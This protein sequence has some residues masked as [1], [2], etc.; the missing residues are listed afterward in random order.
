[1]PPRRKSARALAAEALARQTAQANAAATME[2]AKQAAARSNSPQRIAAPKAPPP[3]KQQ[4]AKAK[5]PAPR[6]S[7]RGRGPP[8]PFFDLPPPPTPRIR[9]DDEE[10]EGVVSHLP[11]PSTPLR[12]VSDDEI[13]EQPSTS[14]GVMLQPVVAPASKPVK[15]GKGKKKKQSSSEEDENKEKESDKQEGVDLGPIETVNLESSDEE[16]QA[17][18]FERVLAKLGD[19]F[20]VVGGPPTKRATPPPILHPMRIGTKLITVKPGVTMVIDDMVH[21][22]VYYF[23]MSQHKKTPVKRL[24]LLKH[25]MNGQKK[26]YNEALAQGEAVLSKVCGIKIVGLDQGKQ[27]FI[28][29]MAISNYLSDVAELVTVRSADQ[30][31]KRAALFLTLVIMFMTNKPLSEDEVWSLICE[32]ELETLMCT[33]R[34]DFHKFMKTEYVQTLYF[35]SEEIMDDADGVGYRYSWGPRAHHE[36]SK[37]AILKFVAKQF[38]G[39][40]PED[41]ELQL[42]IAKIDEREV[43]EADIAAYQA[44]LALAQAAQAAQDAQADPADGQDEIPERSRTVVRFA[45]EEERP[46]SGNLSQV[47]EI[48]T[49]QGSSDSGEDGEERTK[50]GNES[51]NK[52]GEQAESEAESGSDEADGESGVESEGTKDEEEA[53]SGEGEEESG[54][55]EEADGS[56]EEEEE[57]SSESEKEE[58]GESGSGEGEEEGSDEGDGSGSGD[59]GGT[60]DSNEDTGEDSSGEAS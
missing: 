16:H 43:I 14:K 9:Y 35:T 51:V 24:D 40:R 45:I 50:Q 46:D 28:T 32:F 39:A 13:E 21:N 57:G 6:K 23:I 15:K 12:E 29:Y 47:E 49:E 30:Y 53:E 19:R 36:I 17:K 33:K 31:A 1:M 3:K 20:G 18:V 56:A 26:N 34:E 55:G 7:T 27:G 52:E 60:D 38:A 48:E 2:A 4:G 11:P 44:E 41:Y 8:P 25:C 22:I 42:Q 54:S 58:K 10:D 59:Q 37:W 5:T